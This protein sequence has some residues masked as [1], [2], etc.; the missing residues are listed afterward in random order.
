MDEGQVESAS[1]P[2]SETDTRLTKKAR[3][4]QTVGFHFDWWLG[5]VASAA[6]NVGADD[7]FF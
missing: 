1:E 6:Q 5:R 3:M 2:D 4:P 7:S